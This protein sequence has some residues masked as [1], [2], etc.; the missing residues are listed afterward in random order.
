M[1]NIIIGIDIGGTTI[2][3]GIL[4]TAGEITKKW[5]IPTDTSNGGRLIVDHICHSLEHVLKESNQNKDHI[6]GIGLGA[7][8][9]IDAEKG[10]VFEAVNIG[11]RNLEL[12]DLL[13]KNLGLP[14]FLENDANVAV[15]G[16]NWLGAGN[17]DKN[18][19]AV[20]LGTGVGGGIIAN[21]DIL[22]GASGTAGEIGHI[23]VDEKGPLC[24]CG[25][26]GCLE[27]FV[28]ATGMVRQ[29][30]EKVESNPNSKL[31]KR[32]EEHGFISTKDIFELAKD[33]D[34]ASQQIIDFTTNILGKTLS[35]VATVLNPS[36]IL[37]GGGVSKAGSQLLTPLKAAFV[38]YSLPRVHLDCEF[39]IAQ[40][41]NDAGMIGAAYLV[42]QQTEGAVF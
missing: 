13:E 11:W 28:S 3:M 4:T 24:N 38:K 23:T 20:T 7:P 36:K 42:K 29:A 39:K 10:F 2:K 16:E 21:G 37:I 15:L 33:N 8:G 6:M 35:N 40:L 41:G 27:T 31:A 19:L 34:S 32:F 25:R 9:F 12:T 17:Q 18:V 22:N 14:A 5:E 26:K 30:M 1:K